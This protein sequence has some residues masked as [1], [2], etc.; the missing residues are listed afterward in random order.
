MPITTDR[1]LDLRERGAPKNG[2]PQHSDR[3]LYIQLA[4]WGGCRGAQ[5]LTAALKNSRIEGVLYADLY[6]PQGVALIV[7]SESPDFFVNELRD[8]LLKEPFAGLCPKPE[9]A[10][11]GRTYSSGYEQD[12]EDWLIRRPRRVL[13]G[14]DCRWAIWYPLRRTGAFAQLP[15]DEQAQILKEHGTIGRAFGEAG[16]AHDIRL[17]SFGLDRNDNDFVIGLIGSDLHPL[18]ATVEAMRKTRQTS[19][20]MEKMGPFFV[21]RA[22]WQS[23]LN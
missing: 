8:F 22:L 1:F 20:F 2:E 11:F 6:D 17:A 3:R 16:L 10:M 12:L 19:S 9:F 23:P 14:P 21:G 18:S 15:R 4:A 13:G 7:M 5:A